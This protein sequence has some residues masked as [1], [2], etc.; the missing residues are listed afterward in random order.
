MKTYKII[1]LLLA[2]LLLFTGVISVVSGAVMIAT[3]G[4]GMPLEW[5]AGTAF[6]SYLVP[7]LILAIVIA[8]VTIL[9]GILLLKNKKGAHEAAAASGFG[10]LI[11]LFTEMYVLEKMGSHFLHA[12]IFTEALVILIAVM[13][14]IKTHKVKPG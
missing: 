6:A 13:I 1:T 10:L 9:A 11:W 3:D 8:G 5:L 7:G 12:I 14:L 4:M 2:V